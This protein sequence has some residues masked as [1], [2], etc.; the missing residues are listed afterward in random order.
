MG[1]LMQ[2]IGDMIQELNLIGYQ[3]YHSR[4]IYDLSESNLLQKRTH[5]WIYYLACQCFQN[6]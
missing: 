3:I 1:L 6:I 5:G 4:H 2:N